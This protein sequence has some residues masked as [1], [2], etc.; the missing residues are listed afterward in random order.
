MGIVFYING[1]VVGECVY[2]V[3][4]LSVFNYCL[5]VGCEIW[6]GIIDVRVD[7][8]DFFDGGGFEEGRGDMFFNGE[9]GVVGSGDI[10]CCGIKLRLW[11]RNECWKDLRY[12]Y[13]D[14]F[15][16]IFD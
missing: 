5:G 3:C 10:N 15:Y 1:F 8:Y 9:Y 13:F 4:D 11:I 6:Y 7:F 12:I 2:L 14:C 16:S